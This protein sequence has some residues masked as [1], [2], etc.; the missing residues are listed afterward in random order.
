MALAQ[1]LHQ[2]R[3]LIVEDEAIVALSIENKL[4]RLGY[5]IADVV[6]IGRAHV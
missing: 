2:A 1:D 4:K 5:A 6:E 3:V